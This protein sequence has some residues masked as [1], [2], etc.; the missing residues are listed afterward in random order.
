MTERKIPEYLA[1]SL[2]MAADRIEGGDF[3]GGLG[4]VSNAISIAISA[5]VAETNDTRYCPGIFRYSEGSC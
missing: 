2:R 5:I 4:G 3:A 1:K